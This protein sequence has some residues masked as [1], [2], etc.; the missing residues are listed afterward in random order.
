MGI[1]DWRPRLGQMTGI[2]ILCGC[3]MIAPHAGSSRAIVTRHAPTGDPLVIP[4]ATREC[5]GGMT[6]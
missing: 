6:E 5:G 4:C 1:S 3:E 2:A